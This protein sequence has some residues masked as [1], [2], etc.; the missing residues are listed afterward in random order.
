MTRLRRL[1]GESQHLPGLMSRRFA[2]LMSHPAPHPL[3]LAAAAEA[4]DPAQVQDA[5]VEI[6][7]PI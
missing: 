6:N 2:L 1:C 7:H 4:Q 3:L 5:E